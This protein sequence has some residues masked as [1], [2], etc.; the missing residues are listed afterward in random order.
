MVINR[1]PLVALATAGLMVSL[2]ACG[3]GS[4]SS[5]NNSTPGKKGGTLYWLTFHTNDHMDPQRQ[6]IGVNLSNFNRLV[7]RQL[8]TYPITTDLKKGTTPVPDLATD[9]GDEDG[10]GRR[11]TASSTTA[12]TTSKPTG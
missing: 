8:V 5:N 1:K 9:T 7:Y 10:P 6:Y 11:G 2:A 12:I 3:G 4:G